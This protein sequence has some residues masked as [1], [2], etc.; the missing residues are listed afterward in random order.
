MRTAESSPQLY[1]TV[2]KIPAVCSACQYTFDASKTP[3]IAT[4]ALST[5]TLSLTTTDPGAVGFGLTDLK[6]TLNG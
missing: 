2:N 5:D 6:I 4:A 3:S 1:L